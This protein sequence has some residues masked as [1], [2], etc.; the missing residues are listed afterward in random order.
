MYIF[1]FNVI[2]QEVGRLNSFIIIILQKPHF[3]RN[4]IITRADKSSQVYN[5]LYSSGSH[6]MMNTNM[7][8]TSASKPTALHGYALL[9]VIDKR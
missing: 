9:P 4:C 1:F 6:E 5:G 2:D 8:H 3:L 7:R